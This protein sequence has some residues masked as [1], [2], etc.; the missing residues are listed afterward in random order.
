MTRIAITGHRGLSGGVALLID[1]AVRAE[2]RRYPGARL[3]GIS[4][5]A[6]GADQIF[7]RAVLDRGGT[8]EVVVPANRYRDGLPRA[9]QASYDELIRCASRVHRL[10]YEQSTPQSHMDASVA[11]LKGADHLFAAWDGR[12]ARAF[13]GTA[14]VVSQARQLGVP[15]TVIWP[16]G[17]S[18][19]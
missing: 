16:P 11:M 13:G 17:A 8:L 12:P 7:A 1:Q 9:A 10:R 18:R 4:C 3:T 14:D 6:D 19:D 15:V 5:L 2:L